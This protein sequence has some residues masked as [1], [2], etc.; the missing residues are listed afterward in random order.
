MCVVVS[1]MK[2]LH[3]ATR[4]CD[5]ARSGQ[6]ALADTGHLAPGISWH[7]PPVRGRASEGMESHHGEDA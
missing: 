1:F 3:A 6:L 7:H 4:G 2:P 5:I